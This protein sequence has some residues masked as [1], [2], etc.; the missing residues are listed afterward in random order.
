M[1]V[2]RRILAAVAAVLLAGVG[3]L[4]VFAYVAGAE[5]RA[6]ARL[7][8]VEVYVISEPVPTG[9]PA[10]ALGETVTVK[11]LPAEAVVPGA[12]TDL[13]ELSGLVT[14]TDLQPGEQLLAARFAV[15]SDATVVV[16][17]GMHEVS[18]L[19]DSQRVLGGNLTPGATVGVFVSGG[20]DP[21]TR[22]E[23]AHVLITRVQ[24]GLAPPAEPKDGETD[25]PAP[26]PM[27]EGGVMVTMAL[28]PKDVEAVVF[29]AEYESIWLSLERS[30]NALP[31]SENVE[32]E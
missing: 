17:E 31:P 32:S 11:S 10:E 3:A 9:T 18:F 15:P 29:A 4:L 19:L 27:P 16:P 13:D 30:A 20:D 8:P 21:A 6:L 14:V 7:D 28:H 2:S 26:A 25:E 12:V 5:Q 1:N 23:I 24:G 22:L